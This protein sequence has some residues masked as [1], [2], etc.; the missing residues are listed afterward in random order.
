LNH[1][2]DSGIEGT[3]K[4]SPLGRSR[5]LDFD[6]EYEPIAGEIA[7]AEP[8][9]IPERRREEGDAE[10]GAL[11]AYLRAIGPLEVLPPEEINALAE[12][13][14]REENAFRAALFAIPG[15][16][17]ELFERWKQ[18]RDAG[19][20]T[21][22]LAARARDNTG[23]D[24]SRHIDRTLGALEP[25]LEERRALRARNRPPKRRLAELD[26]AIAGRAS[27]AEVSLELLLEIH[28]RYAALLAA[29]HPETVEEKRRLE[30]NT[31]AARA[32]MQR[33]ARALDGYHAAKQRF[34]RH[35]LRLV[36]RVAKRYR[37]MGVPFTDLLQEGNTGLIR[38]VEKY[39]RHRG[40]RFSTYAVWWI[41]QALIRVIQNHSRTV[42]APSHIHELRYRRRRAEAE[43]AHRL[44]REPTDDEVAEQL[45]VTPETFQRSVEA[46]IPVTSLHAVR[47]GTE[48]RTLEDVLA[49]PDVADPS[50]GIELE[51]T[52]SR[53]ARELAGLDERQRR[54]LAWRY[55]LDG[56]PTLTLEE[57]GK[58]L[59][60]S[61]ER[62][63]QIESNALRHLRERD[64]IR[65]LA[66]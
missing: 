9:A 61:R 45:N 16:A 30:L 42:R 21:G 55:G 33:A 54:I 2:H 25:L 56:Q 34:V 6:R 36:V 11:A 35:N 28:A 32:A 17:V 1:L 7:A 22:L 27:R 39:D 65:K 14:E 46:A 62:V 37:N 64:E 51:Q 24:W 40:F 49:D 44:G 38:A 23:R 47:V 4:V 63:R 43:L 58:R 52:W 18:R 12:R 15:T 53:V 57:I 31:P 3:A 13:M 26:A 50:E 48:D 19:Y 29:P 10:P 8:R 66:N 20:V 5:T 60:L 59:G 41:T